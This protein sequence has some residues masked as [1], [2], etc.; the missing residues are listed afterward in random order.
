MGW[1]T[2]E[3]KTTRP[4][5]SEITKSDIPAAVRPL[6]FVAGARCRVTDRNWQQLFLM[7]DINGRISHLVRR[8]ID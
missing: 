6:S 7:N 8:S 2:S 3:R 5:D 4:Q 1:L